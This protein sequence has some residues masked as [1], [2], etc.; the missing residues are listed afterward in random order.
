MMKVIAFDSYS[1]KG[2]N[3]VDAGCDL[4][5]RHNVIQELG[6]KYKEKNK[7][8]KEFNTKKLDD[9]RKRYIWRD[10]SQEDAENLKYDLEAEGLTCAITKD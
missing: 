3:A 10:L 6:D 8:I 5:D 1:G 2:V 4:F 9:G 7:H